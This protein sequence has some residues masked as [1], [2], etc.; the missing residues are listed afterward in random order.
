MSTMD[1]RL[2]SESGFALIEAFITTLLMAVVLGIA[3]TGFQGMADTSDGAS[4]LADTNLNLRNALN[5]MTRDLLSAGRDIPVGGIAIPSGDVGDIVR[6]S[7][8]GTTLSF[9]TGDT[10]MDSITPGAGLGPEINKV[11]TDILTIL[12]VDTSLAINQ[13]PLTFVS[14]DGDAVTVDARTPIDGTVGGITEGDLIMLTTA[15]GST[16]QMVTGRDGQTINF[17][18]SDPMK[19]NQ[20]G[21]TQGTIMQLQTS[22]GVY[23]PMTAT[24]ILMISYYVDASDAERPL[25]MRRVNLGPDRAIGV[26]IENLQLTYDLVDG[27]TNPLNVEK[28]VAPNSPDQIR[29]ANVYLA[30]R[31]YRDWKRTHQPLRASASTQISLR[32]LSF[33]DRYK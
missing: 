19:L 30:G 10:T 32:S 18:E 3:L 26:A 25:L 22:T 13:W 12:M 9:P 33:V 4:L 31:S 8:K 11:K 23:P 6:P 5:V 28:P 14:P 21:A 24:R 2:Q 16:M 27:K 15:S 29:K 17:A 7:P 20:R 1:R